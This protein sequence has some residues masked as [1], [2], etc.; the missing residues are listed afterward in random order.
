MKYSVRWVIGIV[1]IV[2]ALGLA[3]CGNNSGMPEKIEPSRL[4]PI[5]GSDLQRVVLTEKAAER[6]DIQTIPVGEE[7]VVRKRTVGGK[8]V[9]LPEAEGANPGPLWARVSLD[10]GDLNQ[11]ERD[12]PT[13]VLALDGDDEEDRGWPAEPDEG[14]NHDDPEDI[15]LPG[16]DLAE[17][18]YYLIDSPEHGLEVGQAVLVELTLSAQEILHKVVPYTAVLYGVH[19][20]TWV[21]SN[22]EPLV[23]VR[24][25]IVIDYIEGDLAFLSEGPEVGTA[26][27]IVGASELFGTETGVSK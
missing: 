1:L 24:Q 8:V 18:L 13:I 26:V 6:L 4:E 23:Y 21:Y 2:T 27:V 15:D 7:Q 12:L 25:P 17:E 19:G 16:E 5:E 14:P 22:P 3:A 9:T 20:E 11:V 10:K